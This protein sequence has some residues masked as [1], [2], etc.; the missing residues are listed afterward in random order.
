MSPVAAQEMKGTVLEWPRPCESDCPSTR[1]HS[2]EKRVVPS[3]D[4]CLEVKRMSH[5][6]I[7]FGLPAYHHEYRHPT[8]TAHQRLRG[9]SGRSVE[10]TRRRR[11]RFRQGGE[12][13]DVPRWCCS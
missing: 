13:H 1:S 9:T 8:A 12:I 10:Q 7:V 6:L 2:A 3:Q 11:G 5:D 4:R